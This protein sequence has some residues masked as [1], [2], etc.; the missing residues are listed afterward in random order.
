MNKTLKN[1]IKELIEDADYVL[2]GAG[3][4]LSASA[5]LEN[6]G[7]KFNK[8]FADFIKKYNFTDLYTSGFHNF[9]SE[10][11]RWAYWVKHLHMS[12]IDMN[13]TKL[14]EDILNLV[15]N[16]EYFVITTNVDELF[17]K[18]CFDKDKI[19]ATQGS[20][21]YIQCKNG[22]HD[23]LYDATDFVKDAIN[24][25]ENCKIP[26]KLVPVCPVC[27]GEM[28]VHLRVDNNFVQDENWY[29]QNKRYYNF[30]KNAADKKVVLL[31]FGVGFNTP[32]II[33]FP[34]EQMTIEN[35][36]WKLIRFNKDYPNSHL[37]LGDKL[38]KVEGDIQQAIDEISQ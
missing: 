3:A 7:K 29:E 8:N 35:K 26:S 34:F 14:Y 33:R 6:S 36:N 28:D 20:Y 19:F 22:C 15:K 11:E 12:Y 17:N 13:E 24:K 18:A 2:I 10:E 9:K 16:K 23:K 37:E 30:I 1:N 4:G 31:E 27:N 21:K 38:I 25:I 32:G 5:G